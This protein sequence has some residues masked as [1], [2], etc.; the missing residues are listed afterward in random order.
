VKRIL[1]VL[2]FFLMSV[3]PV[4]AAVTVTLTNVPTV[5]GPNPFTVTA[6]INGAGAGNNFLRVDLYKDGTSNYFAETWNDT[7]WYRGA[8]GSGYKRVA[9]VANQA[10]VV[11]VTARA[12]T[13]S[14]SEYPGPGVYKL[15][16]RRYTSSGA[17]ASASASMDVE[18]NLDPISPT[19]TPSPTIEPTGVPEPTAEP[20]AT[21]TLTP[22]VEPTMTPISPTPTSLP[23]VT[24]TP[25]PKPDDKPKD[26]GYNRCLG[27]IRWWWQHRPT[28]FWWRH[29]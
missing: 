7:A 15:R 4:V 26:D 10:A 11:D 23:E 5:I 25:S 9:I 14:A 12:G 28:K 27:I 13:P 19:P 24:A 22:T 20:T 3:T 18:V 8:S 16:V 1:P 17:S 29:W 2:L 6:T 21:P